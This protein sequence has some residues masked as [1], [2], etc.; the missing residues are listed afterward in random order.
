MTGVLPARL[1]RA[2]LIYAHDNAG[3]PLGLSQTTLQIDSSAWTAIIGPN[4]SGKST[5]ARLIAGLARPSS[6]T[7]ERFGGDPRPA[8]RTAVA[9]QSVVLD[10]LLTVGENLALT[11]SMA[12]RRSPEQDAEREA[13]AFG[14]SDR[15][16]TRVSKLSGGLAQRAHVARAF[17]AQRELIVLDEPDAGADADARA[18]IERR[19]KDAARDG[20]AVVTVTHDTDLA[21]SASRLLAVT[22]ARIVMDAPPSEI[23]AKMGPLV[24]KVDRLTHATLDTPE[25]LTRIVD[26]SGVLLTSQDPKAVERAAADLA[27]SGHTVSLGP[28]TLSDAARRLAKDALDES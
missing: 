22:S 18:L 7:I 28:P 27:Q 16:S 1:N 10:P 20:A 4:G 25:E 17:V 11:A 2:A 14:L 21:A 13:E 6:G 26:H 12:G 5:L 8:K 24:A 23:M 19:C 15:I 3:Q 9:T